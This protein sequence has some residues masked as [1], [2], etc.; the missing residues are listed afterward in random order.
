VRE[1]NVLIFDLSGGTFG[2]SLLKYDWRLS[3]SRLLQVIHI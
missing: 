1:K 2:V 3:K